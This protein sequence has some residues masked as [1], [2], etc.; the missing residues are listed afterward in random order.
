VYTLQANK[1]IYHKKK[2]I[3]NDSHYIC[4]SVPLR[5]PSVVLVYKPREAAIGTY[6][7]VK[8]CFIFKPPNPHL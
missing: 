6:I 1:F 2:L 3:Y 8:K 7:G 5:Q 4:R